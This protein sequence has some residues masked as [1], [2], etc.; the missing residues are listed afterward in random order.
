M[1]G[2]SAMQIVVAGA[3]PVGLMT[4]ALLA[5]DKRTSDIS[6][7]VLDPHPPDPWDES[8]ADLRVYA[9]SRAS[10]TLF[11]RLGLWDVIRSCRVSPYRSMR[12][13]EGS[14]ADGRGSV[15]F[16]AAS[17]GE[18]DL[19]HVVED[20][21][22]RHVLVEFLQQQRV[23]I[24]FANWVQD[25][26]AAASRIRLVT[27]QAEKIRADL[28]IG[29][30]G[31]D[32]RVRELV[33]IGSLRR[34]YGQSAL[35]ANVTSDKP[36]GETAWQRF[37]AR[38]PLALLPLADGSS[39]I[40]WS[41]ASAEAE[42]LLQVTDAEFGEQLSNAS[43]NVLGRLSLASRRA[44]FSLRLQHAAEY[45][46]GSVVL[47][48]DA[49]HAVHPLA[50]QGMNLGLLDAA[51]LAGVIAQAAEAGEA[52]GD[53]YV[54]RRYARARRA[55]NLRMQFAFDG[56]DRLFRLPD[57]AAPFRAAGLRAVNSA[58]PLKRLLVEQAMGSGWGG[59]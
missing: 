39:S 31:A 51:S 26:D 1:K 15:H 23:E 41:L 36:H 50:G 8:A 32:S 5:A 35:V 46:R 44:S 17:I 9:L 25:V 21:L 22:L 45:A 59:A 2:A 52:I 56:I 53:L 38:G 6:I 33:G 29:A 43:A 42:R 4:A 7:R 47:V 27:N 20:R 12:V 10:Q 40:V 48:G 18:S 14:D 28:L 58:P 16:E 19:G 37:G 54:L 57:W 30:D 55:H 49:A 11:A 24:S 13:W 3:G 34:D